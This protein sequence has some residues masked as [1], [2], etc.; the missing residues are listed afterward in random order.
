MTVRKRTRRIL[1]PTHAAQMH[2]RTFECRL[3]FDQAFYRT[4]GHGNLLSERFPPL[5]AGFTNPSWQVYRRWNARAVGNIKI[6][7]LYCRFERAKFE[8]MPIGGLE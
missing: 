5:S 7:M 2:S 1:P 8:R 3:G 4:D 6:D